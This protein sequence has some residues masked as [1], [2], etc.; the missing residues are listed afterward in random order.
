MKKYILFATIFILTIFAY[1]ILKPKDVTVYFRY[2]DASFCTSDK[3]EKEVLD[4]FK[5]HNMPVTFAVIPYRCTGDPVDIKPQGVKELT[6]H[7]VK[8]LSPYINDGTLSISLHGY[9]HQSHK[10]EY[11]TE[12]ADMPYKEQY[13]KIKKGKELFKR[14]FDKNITS[15]VPPYNAYDKN[16]VKALEKLGF[17]TLSANNNGIKPR[18]SSLEFLSNTITIDKTKDAIYKAHNSKKLNPYIVVMFHE[19]NFMK[20]KM[21]GLDKPELSFK[22]LDNLLSWIENKKYIHLKAIK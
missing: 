16:T 8:L 4:I 5:K 9:S 12:F 2:D 7:K 19:Y 13:E 17:K 21:K 11:W 20:Q 3:I 1:I 15:F 22:D 6:G 14:V 18:G 10:K